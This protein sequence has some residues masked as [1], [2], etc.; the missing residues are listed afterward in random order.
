MKPLSL[1]FM[2]TPEI[3]RPT[4]E[5]T[6]RAG[7]R[8]LLAVTQPDRRAGRGR[9]VKRGPV[10]ALADE[11]GVPVL[12]PDQA[13]YIVP[14]LQ[15]LQ[16]DLLL[17]LA[18]GQILPAGVLNTGR[19][20]AV[21]LHFSL[22]PLFRGAAPINWAIL[23]GQAKTGVSAMYMDVGLDTGDVIFQEETPIGPQETAGSLA[24]RL[25]KMA[26]GLTLATL[27]AIA[28]GHAPR[29]PQDHGAHTYAPMLKKSDGSLHW[30]APAVELDRRVRGLDPWPGAF[31]ELAGAPLK[32][33]APTKVLEDDHGQRP[34]TLLE[35]S[36]DMMLVACGQGALGIAQVQAAGK[37]RMA[38]ADF[39]RGAR[40][41]PGDRLGS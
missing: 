12:Q 24:E 2:G 20:G 3:A 33:F 37:R 17:V 4:L 8:V 10:A 13:A 22:L 30:G 36:G 23:E 7:H 9:K 40:L 16:P 38:A 15:E 25:A 21:N 11:L 6:A 19:L 32:L 31:S 34:G 29:T 14:R 35:P 27:E 5:A 18:Y 26:A 28:G 39:L 1:V 41:G